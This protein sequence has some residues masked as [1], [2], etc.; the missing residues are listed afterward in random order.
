MREVYF[1]TASNIAGANSL[2]LCRML[3]VLTGRQI[4]IRRLDRENIAH[5][6]LLRKLG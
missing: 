4:H 2:A 1:Y 3:D 6:Y 5:E